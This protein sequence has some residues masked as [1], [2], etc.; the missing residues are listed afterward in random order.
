MGEA[1]KAETAVW[2][3]VWGAVLLGGCSALR[4]SAPTPATGSDEFNAVWDASL[5]VL[6]EGK[7]TVDRTDRREGTITTLPLL[8]RHWFEF[9]R[10]DARKGVD[11]VE[12]T[13]QT[14][15]RQVTVKVRRGEPPAE[16]AAYLASV[17]VRTTRSALPN[18]RVTNTSEAYEMF[19]TPTRLQRTTALPERESPREPEAKPVPLGRDKRLEGLLERRIKDR[20]AEKLGAAGL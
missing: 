19:L 5:E 10:S 11:V 9:W 12:G 18:V 16:G 1:M 6:R 13:L 4:T 8:G 15:H 2:A 17:A 3:V 14:V 20:A 7:F